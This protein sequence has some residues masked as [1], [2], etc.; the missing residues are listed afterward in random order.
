MRKW[1]LDRPG[2]GRI[3]FL[4]IVI[5]FGLAPSAALHAG[6]DPPVSASSASRPRF[7]TGSEVVLKLP[8]LPIFDSGRMV[9]DGDTLTFMVERSEGG[10]VLLVSRD[11]KTRGWAYEDEIVSLEQAIEHF[12]RV[13]VNDLRDADSFWMLGRLWF[14]LNDAKV[15][16]VNLNYA[17]RLPSSQPACYLSRS[18]VHLRMKNVRRAVDDC[19]ARLSS[20][21]QSAQA[22]FVREQA[23]LAK[24]DY[25]SAMAALEQAFRLDPVNPFPRGSASASPSGRQPV[26]GQSDGERG[27]PKILRRRPEVRTTP[28]LIPSGD[29]WCAS[30]SMTRPSMTTTP[31]SSSTCATLPHTRAAREGLEAEYY[32]DGELADYDAAIKLEPANPI[33]PVARAECWSARG[34]HDAAMADFAEVLRL[35]ANNPATWVSRGNESAQGSQNRRRHRRLQPGNSPRPEVRTRLRRQGETPGS[36]SAGPISPFRGFLI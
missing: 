36:R 2:D 24:Q 3:R 15:G 29:E 4:E 10:R 14:Y 8:G 21:A 12:G 20:R 9:D 5:L 1:S 26:A 30:R 6:D 27:V 19:E 22:R 16:L 31:P 25:A 11:G 34:M 32:R 23:E 35:D 17:I 7:A 33:H 28:E 13:L 18:L